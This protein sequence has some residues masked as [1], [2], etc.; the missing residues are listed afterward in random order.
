MLD[1]GQRN[2]R[3][4][5]QRFTAGEDAL[6]GGGLEVWG[7]LFSCLANVRWGSSAERRTVAGDQAV[8]T[9]TFRVLANLQARSVRVTDRIEHDGLSWDVTGIAPI[10]GPAPREIEF[11]ATASRG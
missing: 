2:Q 7:V 1:A 5:F 4:I 11:T 9:A 10:G 8:A 6:G 3:V